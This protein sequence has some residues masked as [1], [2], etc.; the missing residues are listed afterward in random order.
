[1]FEKVLKKDPCEIYKTL[2]WFKDFTMAPRNPPTKVGC[3]G[4]NLYSAGIF[5]PHQRA[6]L[7]MSWNSHRPQLRPAA[8]FQ[9]PNVQNTVVGKIPAPI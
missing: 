2:E 5:G 4:P 6:R 9:G 8:L 7:Y 1:M 3:A